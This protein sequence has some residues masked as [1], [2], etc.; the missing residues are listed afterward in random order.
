MVSFWH[1]AHC[2][3]LTETFVQ[4]IANE[5]N[6]NSAPLSWR[7]TCLTASVAKS[8]LFFL[9][10]VILNCNALPSL[11]YLLSN[12]RE[13][14]RK[15]ACWTISN[16]T[17]GNRA[18][19]QVR[20]VRCIIFLEDLSF[21]LDFAWFLPILS[22][23]ALLACSQFL[24]VWGRVTYCTTLCFVF[25]MALIFGFGFGWGWNWVLKDLLGFCIYVSLKL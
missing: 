10:Q 21:H 1:R 13:S 11:L 15:E 19:I 25:V 6:W 16:I 5:V 17:A 2:S 24:W 4:M 14:I 23:V 9:P 22:K 8:P 18:Q 20:A 12:S 7:L 3:D